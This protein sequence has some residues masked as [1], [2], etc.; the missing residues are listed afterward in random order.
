MERK[1]LLLILST[2]VMAAQEAATTIKCDFTR[3]SYPTPPDEMIPR[4]RAEMDSKL[5]HLTAG[6]D[7]AQKRNVK[8]VVDNFMAHLYLRSFMLG[9]P[10]V[11]GRGWNFASEVQPAALKQVD[12]VLA[13]SATKMVDL[14]DWQL[15]SLLPAAAA[16]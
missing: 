13:T 10:Y 5:G 15:S 14:V 8:E 6:L 3:R 7:D 2:F 4:L 11:P 12:E 16:A 1:T 9:M